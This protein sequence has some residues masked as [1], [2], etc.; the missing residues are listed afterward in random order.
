MNPS[1]E[2]DQAVI[3]EQLIDA[4]VSRIWQALTDRHQMKEW[5]FVLDAF[6]PRVGFEFKFP[7]QGSKGEKYIHLCKITEVVTN[8][9]LQY[10][11]CYENTPG[12]SLVTFELSEEGK[13]TRV[14]LA[15]TGLETFPQGS[16]DFAASS[17]RQ[18]WTELI[19]VLLPKYLSEH[20]K[21]QA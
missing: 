6:E 17:F 9:K 4:P 16:P 12:S 14:R 21:L 18:G 15:H 8:Q 11:W 3:V 1:I 10:S 13:Q 20:S 19:T 5:Y 7:G 2:K